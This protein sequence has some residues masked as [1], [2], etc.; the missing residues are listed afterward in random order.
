MVEYN[1]ISVEDIHH[2]NYNKVNS[3]A[4]QAD[5]LANKHRTN[6]TLGFL[7]IGCFGEIIAE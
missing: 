1:K 6:V 7:V 2:L 5:K 3:F 4:N